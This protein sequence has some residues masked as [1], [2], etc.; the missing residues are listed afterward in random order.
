M[1]CVVRERAGG[2]VGTLVGEELGPELVEGVARRADLAA[3]DV[4]DRRTPSRDRRRPAGE[5]PACGQPAVRLAADEAPARAITGGV[6]V[7]AALIDGDRIDSAETRYL[8][9]P[10]RVRWRL[11]LTVERPPSA[12]VAKVRDRCRPFSRHRTSQRSRAAFVVHAHDGLPVVG[13]TGEQVC[14]PVARG[15]VTQGW[16]PARANR[17]GTQNSPVSRMRR[18]GLEP[19]PG[20][21]GPGPQ[22]GS[23][24]RDACCFVSCGRL[25]PRRGTDWTPWTIWMLSRAL[26]R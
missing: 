8:A 21:P 22:P 26:S 7:D 5:S 24:L 16:P 1:R 2:D 15:V 4:L 19:P 13:N 18:R 11:Q 9:H 3:P 10:N 6:H 20:Y 17:P 14:S 12:S 23:R 25:L